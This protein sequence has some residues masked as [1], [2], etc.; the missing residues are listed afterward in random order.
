MA[1]ID[2]DYRFYMIMVGGLP[3]QGASEEVVP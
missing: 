1:Y 2:N 3:S